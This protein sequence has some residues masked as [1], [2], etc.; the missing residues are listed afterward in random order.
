GS[1]CSILR[2]TQESCAFWISSRTPTFLLEYRCSAS[3]FRRPGRCRLK[4]CFS[5]KDDSPSGLTTETQRTQRR[6]RKKIHRPRSASGSEARHHCYS[7]LCP[8]LLCVLCVSVVRS[9]F[10]ARMCMM[11]P[12]LTGYVLP[13][14]R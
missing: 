3:T 5:L 4:R 2:R 6:E 9:Q 8:G 12:S 11:S 13:S 1:A 7:S 10:V 14:R